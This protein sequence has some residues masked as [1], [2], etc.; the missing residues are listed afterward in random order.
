MFV[1]RL[2][3]EASLTSRTQSP[4]AHFLFSGPCAVIL[5]LF[6]PRGVCLQLSLCIFHLQYMGYPVCTSCA[7]PGWICVACCHL[8]RTP[9]RSLQ[10]VGL[11]GMNV[12]MCSPRNVVGG[13]EKNVCCSTTVLFVPTPRV[14][15]GVCLGGL[16][17]MGW[18][19]GRGWGGGPTKI[20]WFRPRRHPFE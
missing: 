13:T 20:N 1:V 15:L 12:S 5:D 7:G 18:G 6:A 16:W 4:G 10:P 14:W 11:A 8:K 9:E 17:G 2:A 3:S 19:C